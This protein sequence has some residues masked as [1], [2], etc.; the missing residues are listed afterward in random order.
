MHPPCEEWCRKNLRPSLQA[1]RDH[2]KGAELLGARACSPH[3]RLDR[4]LWSVLE[5]K[6]RL[7][8]GS[9]LLPWLADPYQF[10]E[11]ALLAS[12]FRSHLGGIG[13]LRFGVV[14]CL[15]QGDTARVRASSPRR[16]GGGGRGRLW[17]DSLLESLLLGLTGLRAVTRGGFVGERRGGN[18]CWQNQAS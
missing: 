11:H 6:R 2:R 12:L 8:V 9:E 7:Q 15:V 16:T 17:V 1:R 10:A 4:G 5:Q 14:G 18:T 13:S 3:G